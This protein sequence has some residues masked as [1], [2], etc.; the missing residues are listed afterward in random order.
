M[1]LF[2][3]WAIK[4]Y[5]QGLAVIPVDGKKPIVDGYP[6]FANELPTQEQIDK[7]V[8]EFPN[9]N[10]GVVCGK[11]S[12]L[13]IVD[14]DFTGQES[15]KVEKLLKSIL[16][17]TSVIKKGA[18][19]WSSFYQYFEIEDKK[20]I[21]RNGARLVDFISTG[22]MTVI[23]PSIHPDT[24]SPYL[25]ISPDTLDSISTCDLPKLDS[26]VISKI[27]E[28]EFIDLISAESIFAQRSGR[29]DVICSY[30]WAIIE[31]VNSID[32]LAKLIFEYDLK[33]HSDA[34]YFSDKKYFKRKDPMK[35]ALDIAKR[36]EKTVISSKK[37]KG[38]DWHIGKK[39]IVVHSSESIPLE[40]SDLIQH[41]P[42][43][44]G[45]KMDKPIS[46]IENFK[47]LMDA[48]GIKI[49]YNVI[50]KDEEILIPNE[51]FLV[52]NKA[53]ASIACILSKVN[54]FGMPSR[55][56]DEFISYMLGINLYNPVT[57]WI[58]SKKWDGVSRINDLYKTVTIPNYGDDKENENKEKLK[59]VF[60]KRWLISAIAGAF[61]PNGVSAQGV[62]VF[63]GAQ[64]LGKTS[65]FKSLVPSYLNLT[66]DGVILRPDDKDSVKHA[67]S[68]W[69][70][71]L[72]E[73]DAT[74]KKS[75]I[76]QLKAF[77]TKDKDVLR[78]AYA[79]RDSEYARRTVFFSSVNPKQ[80]LQ[81]P[82]GNRRF[83]TVECAEINFKHKIDM[84]QLWA[85]VYE[86]LFL[87]GEHWYLSQDEVSLLNVHNE[88]FTA[89]DPLV[90]K[91]AEE[92]DW[93]A[94][95]HS[96]EYLTTVHI[97]DR[98]GIK[99]PTHRDLITVGVFFA[100]QQSAIKKMTRGIK[101]YLTPPLKQKYDKK[102]GFW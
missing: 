15:E 94:S 74:F 28:L 85:E 42:H 78:R 99:K 14:F 83:W 61:N 5:E 16:P 81:D 63:Q 11:A 44:M 90:E 57:E 67:V 22:K 35:S 30:A 2:S 40:R 17:P 102:E 29:H 47:F 70:V 34:P 7:W 54:Q 87:K 92:L 101:K 38:I 1:G 39:I 23:P 64:N 95:H 4:Y 24:G 97:L 45:K 69:L 68:F 75:D 80:F 46:T 51:S 91:L 32:E 93:D 43:L 36:I 52:D 49:R 86:D 56:I 12:N 89:I 65:W 33:K 20:S 26:H 77:L 72:G 31:K 79:R 8:D 59:Q 9:A 27:R 66:N 100:K 73:L 21:N 82:T 37:K 76:A 84:Q 48:L 60:I 50:T 25:W 71:E 55:N 41:F 10:I 58:L 96:W 6:A 18:R 13:T 98:V 3:D 88:E 19:G 62:L 53:N